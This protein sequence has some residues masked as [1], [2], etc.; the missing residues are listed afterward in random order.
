MLRL[1]N[2]F[3]LYKMNYTLIKKIKYH[4]K[5]TLLAPKDGKEKCWKNIFSL[6]PNIMG[7]F[8]LKECMGMCVSE[9]AIPL[10]FQSA[11]LFSSISFSAVTRPVKGG[12]KQERSTV[13]VTSLFLSSA[14]WLSVWDVKLYVEGPEIQKGFNKMLAPASLWP[15]SCTL[16]VKQLL[17]FFIQNVFPPKRSWKWQKS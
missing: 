12:D 6:D 14:F 13:Q 2:I 17:L 3:P 5:I 11:R 4:K 9:S 7:S 1:R 10:H 16:L 8:P 15:Q